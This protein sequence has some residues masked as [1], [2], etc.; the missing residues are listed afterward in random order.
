MLSKEGFFMQCVKCKS[1]NIVKYG[2]Q[3]EIQRFKCKDCS[4]VFQETNPK[5]TSEF[6]LECIQ[7]YVNSCGIRSIARVK[8]IPNSLVIY[9]IKKISDSIRDLVSKKAAIITKEDIVIMEVDELCTYIKKNLIQIQK[10][11]KESE[12]IL[13]YG[14]LSIG[15]QTKFVI[16]K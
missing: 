3:L 11:K 6:K 1:Q 8:S 13:G 9:W 2:K 12:S 14:L 16:L 5:Y 4:K 7:M 10:P 15:T